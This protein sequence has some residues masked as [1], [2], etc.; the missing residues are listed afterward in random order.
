MYSEHIIVYIL[1]KFLL[2]REC[3]DKRDQVPR[4]MIQPVHALGDLARV[5][6]LSKPHWL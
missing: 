4:N 2:A 3:P 5:G 1:S 6:S